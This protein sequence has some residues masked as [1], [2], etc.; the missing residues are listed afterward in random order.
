V[1]EGGPGLVYLEAMACGLP[2]IACRGNGA[3]EVVHHEESGFL[4]PPRDAQAV[5]EA[6]KLLLSD[7]GLRRSMG[8]RA[9]HFVEAEADSRLCLDRLEAFYRSAAGAKARKEAV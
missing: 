7:A 4:V 6:L 1:Y 8:L 2:V 3:S 9:R 5:A